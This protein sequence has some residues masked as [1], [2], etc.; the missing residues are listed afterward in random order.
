MYNSHFAFRE[1]PFT[2]TPDP[3]FFYANPIYQEAFAALTY[4]IKAKKGFMVITAEVGT[5]KT[6]V[7]RELMRNLHATIHT[8]FIFNTLVT[9]PEL[10]RLILHDLGLF[11][12]EKDKL[13]MLQDLNEY[14]VQQL[15]KGHTVAVLIDEAQNLSDDA[16]EGLIL[17]SNL[18]TAKEKLL[19]IILA[20][21]PELDAKLNRIAFRQ[22]KQRIAVRCRLDSL[23]DK[24]IGNYIAHRLQV[25]GY[26]GP[27]IFSKEAIEEIWA[28]SHG[29]PRLTNII[30]DNALMLAYARDKHLIERTIINKVGHDLWLKPEPRLDTAEIEIPRVRSLAKPVES[31]HGTK[32]EP[33]AIAMTT[34]L[35]RDNRQSSSLAGGVRPDFIVRMTSALTEAMGPMAPVVVRR[36]IVML[37]ESLET[38]PSARLPELVELIGR[39]VLSRG[40]KVEFERTMAAEMRALGILKTKSTKLVKWLTGPEASA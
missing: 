31:D 34:P 35:K 30:C 4:G 32:N 13:I 39:N 6:T 14:L 16:L 33:R 15:K 10:L 7:L 38:F 12:E 37:G 19:Q 26:D 20:G 24:E 2:V 18:E 17:L 8:A 25:A 40:M 5:G 21:Q 27:E 9:F 11:I 1:A 23:G 28:Y 3:N 22:L 29:N 36:E